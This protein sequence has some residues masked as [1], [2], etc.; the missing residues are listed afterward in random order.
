MDL[1]H[2]D[3]VDLATKARWN[4]IIEETTRVMQHYCMRFITPVSR[5]VLA[6]M[7]APAVE[8]S[9][10]EAAPGPPPP[11]NREFSK[12]REVT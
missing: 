5:I 6:A 12:E 9:G 8:P 2:Q 1:K 3:D 4:G 11:G 10:D 7:P